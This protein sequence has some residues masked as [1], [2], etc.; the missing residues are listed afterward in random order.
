MDRGEGQQWSR[1]RETFTRPAKD[2][3][4][5]EKE[6]TIK[7]TLNQVIPAI[8]PPKD[9]KYIKHIRMQSKLLSDFWGRPMHL[10]ANILLP[11]GFDSHPNARYPLVIF[12][13]H[14]PSDF[15]GFGDASRSN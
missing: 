15:G 3:H 5:S 8:A 9:T 13:G 11:E 4:R 14:F 1:R 2:N 6:A 10:G 7:L 12:H